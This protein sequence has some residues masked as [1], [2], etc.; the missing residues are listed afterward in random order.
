MWR[1]QKKNLPYSPDRQTNMID[2]TKEEKKGGGGGVTE[3][4][5]Q[6]DLKYITLRGLFTKIHHLGGHYLAPQGKEG[7]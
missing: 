6:R 2:N 5:C 7:R 3:L 4:T 1:G